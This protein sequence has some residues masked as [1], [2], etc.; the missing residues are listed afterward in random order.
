MIYFYVYFCPL[1]PHHQDLAT[2]TLK[3]QFGHIFTRT[4]ETLLFVYHELGELRQE[5]NDKDTAKHL[6]NTRQYFLIQEMCINYLSTCM[7]GCII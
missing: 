3:L 4:I 1:P 7:R 2:F 5:Y 6:E